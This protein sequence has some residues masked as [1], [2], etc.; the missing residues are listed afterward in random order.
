MRPL[1]LIYPAQK[2]LDVVFVLLIRCQ[3]RK[4]HVKGYVVTVS[5]RMIPPPRTNPLPAQNPVPAMPSLSTHPSQ[6]KPNQTTKQ[7]NK[8][9]QSWVVPVT[10]ALSV[11]L[12]GTLAVVGFKA[13]KQVL[14]EAE[15]AE[16][17]AE[18]EAKKARRKAEAALRRKTEEARKKAEAK[19]EKTVE[20]LWEEAWN[21]KPGSSHYSKTRTWTT[22]ST[23]EPQ[24]DPWG[25]SSGGTSTQARRQAEAEAKRREEAYTQ[26]KR[27]FEERLKQAQKKQAREAR[28]S[29]YSSQ[30]ST[31]GASG[32]NTTFWGPPPKTSL[33]QG[34][35]A[36]ANQHGITPLG[37]NPTK[38]ELKSAYRN[39]SMKLHP[40]TSGDSSTATQFVELSD[41]Y[42]KLQE[43]LN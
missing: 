27:D 2:R 11:L 28:D 41:I 32:A 8:P 42:T 25:N 23:D 12:L 5:A 30:S 43:H 24:Q 15:E 17:L 21:E 20:E 7:I 14:K 40:D 37:E 6:T 9:T 4:R 35:N 33:I 13:H 18:A 31:S 19:A 10:V 29:R 36:L 34:F 39:L 38:A 26:W 16:K 1:P 22:Y 3:C